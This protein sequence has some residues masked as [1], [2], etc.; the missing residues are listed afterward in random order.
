[1]PQKKRQFERAPKTKPSRYVSDRRRAWVTMD[2]DELILYVNPEEDDTDSIKIASRRQHLVWSFDLTRLSV[3]ELEAFKSIFNLAFELAHPLA[4][5]RDR[6]ALEDHENGIGTQHRIYRR[7]PTTV[8]LEG[9]ERE[10][11][12]GVQFRPPPVPRRLRNGSTSGGG[13]RGDGDDVDAT[14]KTPDS[15]EDHQS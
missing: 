14:D 6:K 1:M 13:V 4:A 15:S 2:G 5:E 7:L 12:E 9:D 3:A 10:Y 8:G 11:V